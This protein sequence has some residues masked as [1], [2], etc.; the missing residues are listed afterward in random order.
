M[1]YKAK[2]NTQPDWPDSGP[3]PFVSPESLLVL[4]THVEAKTAHE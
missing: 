3:A 2:S 1:A 4:R